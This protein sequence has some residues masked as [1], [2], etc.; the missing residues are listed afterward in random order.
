MKIIFPKQIM[1]N[2]YRFDIV[3]DPEQEGGSFSFSRNNITIGTK[4]LE[5]D[6]HVVWMVICHEVFEAAATALNY[7]YDDPSVEGNW[8]FFMDHKEFENLVAVA[9]I[10]LSQFV[11]QADD[12]PAETIV[13]EAN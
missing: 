6:P 10:A 2:C 11:V 7:R 5:S 12:T 13:G 4:K 3:Q 8:K 9:S 1:L